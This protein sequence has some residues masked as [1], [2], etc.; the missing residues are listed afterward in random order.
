MSYMAAMGGW[1]VLDYAENF[2]PDPFGWLQLGYASYLSSWALMNTGP[3]ENNYGFWFPGPENDGASGWQ[4]TSTKTGSAWMGS[5]FPGGVS[6]PRGP[7]HYDG[8]IDL[9]YGG[10]LRMAATVVTKDPTF[11]WFA[12]GAM[13][14]ET[15]NDLSVNPRDGLRRRLAVVVPDTRLPFREDVSRFKL[16]LERDGFAAD[17]SIVMDKALGKISATIENRTNNAHTT[18]VRL[19]FPLNSQYELR[20]DGK[21][22]PLVQ[23]GDWDY[24]WRADLSVAG[25]TSK[26]ELVRR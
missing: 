7:W 4:F 5:S 21:V 26:I 23:T 2:A 11:G 1:G 14:T 20:Q 22:V 9:G 10:A 16:E 24:P 18:G 3:A 12:Y 6:E 25:P 13:M 15:A 8:E 19:S 17:Q